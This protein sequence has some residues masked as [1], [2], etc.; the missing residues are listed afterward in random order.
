MDDNKLLDKIMST[1]SSEDEPEHF[2][3]QYKIDMIDRCCDVLRDF[4]DGAQINKTINKP[5]KSMGFI[6]VVGR[7]IK[8]L[9]SE[10]F[11]A[12]ASVASNVD[13]YPKADG[14]LEIDFTFHGIAHR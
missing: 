14:S 9:T 13:I 4:T 6:S 3:I 1:I 10:A 5:F 11:L 8:F 12:V 2:N 7:S